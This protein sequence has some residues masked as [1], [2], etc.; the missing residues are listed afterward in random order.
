MTTRYECEQ[1]PYFECDGLSEVR[2]REL[3]GWSKTACNKAAMGGFQKAFKGL[4]SIE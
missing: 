2:P 4:D 3:P 1:A